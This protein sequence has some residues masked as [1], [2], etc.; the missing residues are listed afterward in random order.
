MIFG[1][2]FVFNKKSCGFQKPLEVNWSF[3]QFDVLTSSKDFQ[4]PDKKYPKSLRILGS[5]NICEDLSSWGNQFCMPGNFEIKASKLKVVKGNFLQNQERSAILPLYCLWP[6]TI[7]CTFI[8]L[9]FL[10]DIVV[11]VRRLKESFFRVTQWEKKM[12]LH[13]FPLHKS[14]LLLLNQKSILSS[15][16]HF[17]LLCRTKRFWKLKWVLC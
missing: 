16:V 10:H 4:R 17:Q 7:K 8:R 6:L 11:I 13:F 5:N 14:D 12:T 1:P 2:A 9:Y 3:F 15:I